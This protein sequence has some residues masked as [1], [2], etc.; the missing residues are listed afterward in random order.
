MRHRLLPPIL[1]LWIQRIAGDK[2]YDGLDFPMVL[3][4]ALRSPALYRKST[5]S[6]V[7]QQVE[8]PS[9]QSR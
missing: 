7:S 5:L 4:G 3:S 6:M 2:G 1:R 9:G 8:N